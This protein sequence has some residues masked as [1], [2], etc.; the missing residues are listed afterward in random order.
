MVF[1]FE[2]GKTAVSILSCGSLQ[3]PMFSGSGWSIVQKPCISAFLY[4]RVGSK[5]LNSDWLVNVASGV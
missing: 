2:S 1:S 4:S 5:S 3:L